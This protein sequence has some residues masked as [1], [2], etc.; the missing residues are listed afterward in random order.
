MRWAAIPSHFALR[1]PPVARSNGKQIN[2]DVGLCALRVP[3]KFSANACPFID[4]G[5]SRYQD[6]DS[7]STCKYS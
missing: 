5:T 1:G 2:N 7:A 4:G 6:L 3:P